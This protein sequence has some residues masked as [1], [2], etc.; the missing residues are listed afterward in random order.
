MNEKFFAVALGIAERSYEVS[1]G[2][3]AAAKALTTGTTL[4]QATGSP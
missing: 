2:Q 1:V 4:P 3:D